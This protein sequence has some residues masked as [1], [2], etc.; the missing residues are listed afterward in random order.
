MTD[1]EVRITT[2]PAIP[3]ADITPLEKLF[4][5]NV[6]ECSETE[7]GLIPFTDT[8]PRNPIRVRQHELIQAFE[9]SKHQIQSALNAFVAT[10]VLGLFPGGALDPDAVVDIDLNEFPWLFIVQDIVARSATLREVI[11]IQWIN[12]LSQ[13]P[14]TFGASV[15]LITAKAIHHATS[16]DLLTRFRMLDT[17]PQH[18]S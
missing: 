3:L 16:E 7:D 11:V 14:E 4:L 15:S 12:H 6:L 1:L 5:S 13:R 10:C 2:Y 8:G 17:F 18:E 9:A